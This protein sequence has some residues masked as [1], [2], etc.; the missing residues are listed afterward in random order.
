MELIT[1]LHIREEQN[2]IRSSEEI[3]SFILDD[4][5]CFPRIV[6]GEILTGT[7]VRLMTYGEGEY[8]DLGKRLKF[9]KPSVPFEE[10]EDCYDLYM[11]MEQLEVVS[12][13]LDFEKVGIHDIGEIRDEYF[14][15]YRYVPKQ[16]LT[17]EVIRFN[18]A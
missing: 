18:G 8:L 13:K 4:F 9:V 5:S 1:D 17:L 12:S 6:Y 2:E 11:G 10:D 15:E 14:Q 7:F 3:P 16:I